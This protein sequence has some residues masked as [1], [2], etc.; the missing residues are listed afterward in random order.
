M[1]KQFLIDIL[2]TT[3]DEV[4]YDTP[5]YVSVKNDNGLALI[6]YHIDSTDS[7]WEMFVSNKKRDDYFIYIEDEFYLEFRK[8]LHTSYK[9]GPIDFNHTLCTCIILEW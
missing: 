8:E 4:S 2:F 9:L 5:I 3:I 6:W 1:E 7:L